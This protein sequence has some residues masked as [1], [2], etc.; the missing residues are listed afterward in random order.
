[1]TDA[2][3]HIENAA[4][5]LDDAA[6]EV[7]AAVE[8]QSK[9]VSAKTEDLSKAA[10]EKAAAAREWAAERANDARDWALDQSDVIRDNVQ[11]KPFIAIGVSAAS[12]FAAG[13]V[14]GILLST[15]R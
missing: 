11:S 8:V 4:A 3:T 12:A 15:R 6:S 10:A 9:T 1:M 5:K 7:G 2:T 14:L 13:L